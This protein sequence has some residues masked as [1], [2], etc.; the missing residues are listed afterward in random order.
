MTVGAEEQTRLIK[1][2]DDP[3]IH[4]TERDRKA[5]YDLQLRV[6]KLSQSYRDARTAITNLRTELTARQKTAETDKA[7][8]TVKQ[9]LA[10]LDKQLSSTQA[11]V[12][13]GRRAVPKAP[14]KPAETTQTSESGQPAAPA[15]QTQA[16]PLALRLNRLTSSVN[17]GI[18]EP[19]SKYQKQETDAV[20]EIVREVVDSVNALHTTEVA[21]V[22]KTLTENKLKAITVPPAMARP[23]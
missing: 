7:P 8:E 23:R 16:S 19:V 21:R 1:V 6:V 15:A 18:T 14:E 3:R 11:I 20:A 10:M 4:I 13:N 17:F 22:N 9:S 2:E 5:L 12:A